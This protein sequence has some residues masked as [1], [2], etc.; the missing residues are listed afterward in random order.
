[1]KIRSR[2]TLAIVTAQ[3]VIVAVV[4]WVVIDGLVRTATDQ[5]ARQEKLIWSVLHEA[6]VLAL[7]TQAYANLQGTLVHWQRLADLSTV[8]VADRHA[9]IVAATEPGFLGLSIDQVARNDSNVDSKMEGIPITIAGAVQGYL[10]VRFLHPG[11]A[12]AYVDGRQLA[13]KIAGI[14]IPFIFVSSVLI[15]RFVTRRLSLLGQAL[16]SS[17]P[18]YSLSLAAPFGGRDEI[19]ELAESVETMRIRLRNETLEV[20]QREVYF[21]SVLDGLPTMVAIISGDGGFEQFNTAWLRFSGRNRDDEIEN[22]NSDVHQE[23]LERLKSARNF[24]QARTSTYTLEYRR[25]SENGEYRWLLEQ[26]A[27]ARVA[28]CLRDRFVVSCID[29]SEQKDVELTLRRSEERFQKAF[30]VSPDWIAITTLAEGRI[31]EVN[32][33]FERLTGYSAAEVVG[34]TMAQTGLWRSP[35]QRARLIQK[36]AEHHELSDAPVQFVTKSGL[37]RDFIGSAQ[38]MEIEGE[39]CLLS[40]ARDVTLMKEHEAQLLNYQFRLRL[41]TRQLTDAQEEERRR[42]AAHIHDEIAQSLALLKITTS[43]MVGLSDVDVMQRTCAE[44]IVVLDDLIEKTR[45]LSLQLSPPVLDQ[46]GIV[47]AI[48][49]FANRMNAQELID[50][51]VMTDNYDAPPNDRF[52]RV[53]FRIVRELITNVAKHAGCASCELEL[54]SSDQFVRLCVR[55]HGCGFNPENVQV[56]SLGLFGIFEAIEANGGTCDIDSEV[57]RG[58]TV[59]VALSY[60]P[61]EAEQGW[62][63]DKGQSGAH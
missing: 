5:S 40:I 21:R 27:P 46:L 37:V 6:A 63:F 59:N 55:D 3:I 9:R 61:V 35:E 56:E 8:V 19:N 39:T 30:N 7:S 11:L 10:T 38:V 18:S 15:N 36:L 16:L 44:S 29:I 4:G 54:S 34:K 47:A 12:S 62:I 52:D 28:G 1:M 58:T 20:G 31:V 22:Q 57:G 26:G 17:E 48:T 14:S 60:G 25:R 32:R 49:W 42:I 2:V 51:R 13:L 45:D 41:L 23:D 43:R 53:I 24:A 33:G 50:V